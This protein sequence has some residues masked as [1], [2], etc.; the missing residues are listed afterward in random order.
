MKTEKAQP[1]APGDPCPACGDELQPYRTATDAEYGK[2][3]DREQP[4][5]LPT[6][7]DSA[8]PA[9]AAELGALHVCRGCG[10][11][12]RVAPADDSTADAPA[13]G[14]T[15]KRATASNGE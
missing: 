9:Q 15:S 5:S 4:G 2:A 3:F 13:K 6:R 12:A 7:V 10:Y 8:S 1:W 11:Q 14:K